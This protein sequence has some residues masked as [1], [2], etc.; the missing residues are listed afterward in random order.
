MFSQY[1]FA[2]HV[3]FKKGIRL[4]LS[5]ADESGVA[6]LDP[7]SSKMHWICNDENKHVKYIFN[8]WVA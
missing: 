6:I 5:L 8:I 3:I 7:M 2:V 1:F 4:W